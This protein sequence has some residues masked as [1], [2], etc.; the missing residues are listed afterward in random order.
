MR[1]RGGETISGKRWRKRPRFGFHSRRNASWWGSD[2][3][4]AHG[5]GECARL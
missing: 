5:G 2:E 3:E 1:R 4:R